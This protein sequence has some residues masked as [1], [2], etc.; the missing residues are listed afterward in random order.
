MPKPNDWLHFAQEDLIA[1]KTLSKE[2]VAL[3]S[4]FYHCQQSA[5]KSL[6]GYLLFRDYPIK[7]THDLEFLCEL[8]LRFDLAFESIL[9]D[10]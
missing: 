9:E 4:V 7:K 5:E 3:A 10:A 6:K 8:C 1:A 2:N